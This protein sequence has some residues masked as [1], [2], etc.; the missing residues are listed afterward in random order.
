VYEKNFDY[1]PEILRE[2]IGCG[3]TAYVTE[4]ISYDKNT[5]FEILNV[6]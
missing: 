1:K 2:D 5:A 4:K 3:I 6:L